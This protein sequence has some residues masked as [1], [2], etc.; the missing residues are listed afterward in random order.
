[1]LNHKAAFDT[2]SVS[3]RST[4]FIVRIDAWKDIPAAIATMQAA[5][6]G[7]RVAPLR[8]L[9][10]GRIAHLDVARGTSNNKVKHF[11][12]AA[13]RPEL[14][15]IGDDDDLPSGPDGFATAPR[16]LKW[17]RQIVLHGAGGE[18]SHYE[19]AVL[20]AQITG[21]VV[22]VECTSPTIPAW[23][24]ATR[25]WATTSAVQILHPPSGILHPKPMAREAM[26]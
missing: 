1:M 6:A 9:Y 13:C 8:A 18:A 26:Q 5:G 24:A 22:M 17:A 23:V 11:I 2:P 15:I 16:L 19:Q 20:A 10:E 7:F 14:V 12:A 4:S 3:S 21:R 25:K